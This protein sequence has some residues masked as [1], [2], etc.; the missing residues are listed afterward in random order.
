MLFEYEGSMQE[1]RAR[2]ATAVQMARMLGDQDLE[3]RA[4]NGLGSADLTEGRLGDAL[5]RYE[6]ALALAR[7]IGDQRMQGNLLGNLGTVHTEA[8]R[9]DEA[10]SHVRGGPGARARDGASRP[11]SRHLVQSGNDV[12]GPRPP[13]RSRCGIAGGVV[14][15]RELG[16]VRLESVGPVQPGY[17]D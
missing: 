10:V 5:A 12:H 3:C 16:H 13:G 7:E 14:V 6:P 8:G 1:G 9:V 4:I 17:R 15:A 2:Y 11:R